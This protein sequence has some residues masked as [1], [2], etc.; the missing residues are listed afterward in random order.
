MLRPVRESILD[1][2][3]LRGVQQRVRSIYRPH[4]HVVEL[5]GAP[6]RHEPFLVDVLQ[7]GQV[8]LDLRDVKP[9]GSDGP[10][11]SRRVNGQELLLTL[12]YLAVR[13]GYVV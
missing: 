2:R 1:L 7:V 9:F 3:C 5:G 13:L 8:S 10:R 4:E 6:L 12:V 11:E